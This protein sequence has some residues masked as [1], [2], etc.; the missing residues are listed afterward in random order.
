MNKVFAFL[1][2]TEKM[3]VAVMVSSLSIGLAAPPAIG[4]AQSTGRFQMDNS[5]VSGTATVFEGSRIDTKSSAPRIDLQS[6]PSFQLSPDSRAVVYGN[7]AVIEQG[8][9]IFESSERASGT[10]QVQARN[11][12]IQSDQGAGSARVQLAGA[13]RVQVAALRGAVRVRNAQGVL[14]ASL[15]PGTSLEFDP[16]AS[17]G[18]KAR[19]SGC[20][21]RKANRF[22]LTDETT[23][24]TMELRG[25]GLDKEVGNNVLVNGTME[26]VADLQAINVTTIERVGKGCSGRVGK[27]AAGA[28]AGGAAAATGWALSGTT[29]AIIGGVAAAA[30]VGGLAA[31]DKLPGQGSQ[32]PATIS[33]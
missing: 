33:K 7:R 9:G 1:G 23:S 26:A 24:V 5:P 4:I 2:N 16:Q 18:G 20:L 15:A 10:F 6:G 11:L 29:I 32:T 27:A 12:S 8:G 19:V 14:V 21:Q 13:T 30:T 17:Q 22:M 25:E 31:V 3:I 28:G